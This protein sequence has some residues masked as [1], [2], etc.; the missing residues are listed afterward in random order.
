M[1]A[2]VQR[3]PTPRLRTLPRA[4]ALLG[5]LSALTACGGGSDDDPDFPL[6]S[7]YKLEWTCEGDCDLPF[8]YTGYD[9]MEIRS[10]DQQEVDVVFVGPG[11]EPAELTCA[12]GV[13]TCQA[14]TGETELLDCAALP[15][16]E[17][18]GEPLAELVLCQGA[19]VRE[20]ESAD[21]VVS[22]PDSGGEAVHQLRV[23]LRGL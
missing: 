19:T 20:M 2:T 22:D 23:N 16:C 21:I 4:L 17:G 5:A 8:P 9:L 1:I 18:A 11:C 7:I 10:G 12:L 15:P 14:D 6:K 3:R 13:G